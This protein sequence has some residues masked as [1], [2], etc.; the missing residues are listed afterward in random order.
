MHKNNKLERI[1]R[2]ENVNGKKF[3]DIYYCKEDRTTF[4]YPENSEP[5]RIDYK[6]FK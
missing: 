1:G 5:K 4:I 3:V 2:I 6:Y